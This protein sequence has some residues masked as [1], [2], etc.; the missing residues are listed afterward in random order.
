MNVALGEGVAVEQMITKEL[1]FGEL[2]TWTTLNAWLL[3]YLL[4]LLSSPIHLPLSCQKMFNKH[5]SHDV[6][7]LLKTPDDFLLLLE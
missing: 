4:P 6:S 7:H 5:N 2:R 3:V 1:Q